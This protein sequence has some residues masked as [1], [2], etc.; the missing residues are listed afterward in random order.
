MYNIC[1][2]FLIVPSL[3]LLHL[4][5]IHTPEGPHREAH[6]RRIANSYFFVHHPPSPTV[7]P[8]LQHDTLRN[9]QG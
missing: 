9:F 1:V 4:H 6:G 7:L 5:T 8:F 2:S 3:S